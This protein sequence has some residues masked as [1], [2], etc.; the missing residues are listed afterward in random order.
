VR[1]SRHLLPMIVLAAALAAGTA[2]CGSSG[3][4]AT[5][6]GNSP[7]TGGSTNA[8][9]GLTSR[10]VA[11]KA[12]TG[13][14]A[15][16]AVRVSG[17]GEDSGQTITMDL[18]LV[19]GKGCQGTVSEAQL[20]SFKLIFNGA[21]VWML[22]DAKFYQ[23]EKIP[24]A[25]VALLNGKYIEVKSTDSNMGS[26]ATLCSLSGLL[27]KITPDA[28]LAKGVKTTLNGVPA[29]KITDK[30]G[31]GVA[32][33]SDSATPELLQIDKT[34][35]NGGQLTFTYFSTPP[36]ITAPPTSQT[37]DGSKYGF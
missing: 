8:L 4:P 12:V 36:A 29:V 3:S 11:T 35:S 5:T 25:A 18:T 34:G 1:N 32:Y 23:T 14:E 31:A 21:D 13:T 24:A 30:T 37:I 33:V 6:S 22:P 26:L 16:S 7:T 28:S 9:A 20:G 15:A 27:G 17:S 10:Q 2:A 19:K